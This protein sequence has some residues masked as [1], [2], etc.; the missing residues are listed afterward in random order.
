MLTLKDFILVVGLVGQFYPFAAAI[1]D[2][3]ANLDE[4]LF[5]CEAAC[6]EAC[7]AL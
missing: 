6:N 3:E 1:P 2:E 7:S 4:V 5:N